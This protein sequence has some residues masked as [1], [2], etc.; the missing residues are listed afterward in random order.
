MH[1]IIKE[2]KKKKNRTGREQKMDLHHNLKA[3][4]WSDILTA[5]KYIDYKLWSKTVEVFNYT[6][7]H[8]ITWI[9]QTNSVTLMRLH[10]KV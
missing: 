10:A 8:L 3:E 4:C 1:L 2:S 5:N 7:S 6:H 9:M